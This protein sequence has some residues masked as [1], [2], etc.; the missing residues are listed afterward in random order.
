MSESFNRKRQIEE[1]KKVDPE[2]NPYRNIV[3]E[4]VATEIQNRFRS[5]FPPD[6]IDSFAL[7]VRNM[8]K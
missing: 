2:L 3:I 6:T 1:L 7:F 4:E 5:S 8:K